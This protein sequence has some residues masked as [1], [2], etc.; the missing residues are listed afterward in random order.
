MNIESPLKVAK[1]FLCVSMLIIF[2]LTIPVWRGID[3]SGHASTGAKAP[4]QFPSQRMSRLWHKE[5]ARGLPRCVHWMRT[6]TDS[7]IAIAQRA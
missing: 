5:N 6:L 2:V 1:P 4:G 7:I 3:L